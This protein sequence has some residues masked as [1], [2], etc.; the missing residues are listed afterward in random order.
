ME[1]LKSAL[2]GDI[3]RQ[4][5]YLTKLAED[6]GSD[7]RFEMWLDETQRLL[8]KL[9][10]KLSSMKANAKITDYVSKGRV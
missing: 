6:G 1:I 10:I 4:K 7:V 2:E 9:S 8:K 5:E 3:M